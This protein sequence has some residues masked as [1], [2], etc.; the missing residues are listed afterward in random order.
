M[1]GFI[2]P[3]FEA[4]LLRPASENNALGCFRVFPEII[5]GRKRSPVHW[6]DYYQL[7]FVLSGSCMQT[8]EG[9]VLTQTPGTMVLLPPYTEHRWDTSASGTEE[10]MLVRV[11]IRKESALAPVS[12]GRGRAALGQRLLPCV[13]SFSG[14]D[15][16]IACRLVRAM[17]EEAGKRGGMSLRRVESLLVELLALY[18]RAAGI[19]AEPGQ[20]RREAARMQRMTQAAE[21][22]T[23]HRTE[24][25]GL[26]TVAEYLHVSRRT[27]SQGFS[28]T[29]GR[30]V[31][32]YILAERLRAA[33]HFLR[34]T[35]DSVEAVAL[36]CGFANSSHLSSAFKK[37]FGCTPLQFRRRVSRWQKDYGDEDFR[38][39]I[40]EMRWYTEPTEESL[41]NHYTSM[42]FE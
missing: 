30:T 16:E 20:L 4:V 3:L 14:E 6:H 5:R 22:I 19:P 23:A 31:H 10:R 25:M 37:E 34:T 18:A 2:P 39:A 29:M 41:I 26:D 28:E 42:S 35:T 9:E 13:H 17:A 24:Q 8:V 11:N 12:L 36:R 27:L 15:L 7:W 40:R 32:A 38:N 21:Y 1:N 33:Y